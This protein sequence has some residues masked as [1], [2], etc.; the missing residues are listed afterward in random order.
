MPTFEMSSDS[1]HFIS[2]QLEFRHKYYALCHLFNS[3]TSSNFK[4]LQTEE[5]TEAISENCHLFFSH[6]ILQH[7]LHAHYMI[8]K[9]EKK[10]I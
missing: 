8:M 5:K 7:N 4:D 9:K 3:L 2:K 1:A 10:T 6:N